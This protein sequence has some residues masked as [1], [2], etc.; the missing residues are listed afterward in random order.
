M[1]TYGLLIGCGYGRLKIGVFGFAGE[2]F[3]VQRGK[4]AA[5]PPE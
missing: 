2:N 3:P 4:I 5:I 1:D